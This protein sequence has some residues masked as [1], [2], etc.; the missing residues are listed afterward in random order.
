MDQH[1]Y[2]RLFK[3]EISQIG[4]APDEKERKKI[5]LHQKQK[6]IVLDNFFLSP[7]SSSSCHCLLHLSCKFF[8]ASQL[9]KLR[10]YG[11][12]SDVAVTKYSLTK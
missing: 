5:V 1:N 6:K 9:L 4:L 12:S 11:I 7:S 3:D 8:S 10:S 2:F